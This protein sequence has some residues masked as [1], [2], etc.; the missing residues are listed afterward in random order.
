MFQTYDDWKSKRIMNNLFRITLLLTFIFSSALS[1]ACIHLPYGVPSYS[2]YMDCREGYA[3]GYNYSL[4]SPEWVAYKLK[5]Q[6]PGT[7]YE[8]SG[9]E[10]FVEDRKIPRQFRSTLKDYRGSGFHRGHLANSESID[11]SQHANEE[12]FI[13]SNIVPQIGKHN[14]GIWKGL[15]NRERKWANT[16]GE[17]YVI[18][19]PAYTSEYQTIGKNQIPVPDYLWKIIYEPKQQKALAFFTEHKPLTTMFLNEY[20]YS[21]DDLEAALNMNFLSALPDH[22][23]ESIESVTPKQQW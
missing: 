14:K 8:R 18:T 5:K 17:V 13:L 15:E 3:I 1:N 9:S 4:K 2:D 6:V 11:T 19:G 20:L 16:F 22:I 7:E 12:T 21:V 23:E 10:P